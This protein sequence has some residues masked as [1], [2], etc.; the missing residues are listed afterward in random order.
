VPVGASSFTLSV[1][2][3]NSSGAPATLV[4]W[5]DFDRDNVF[6][7]DEA[8]TIAIPDGTTSATPVS[9]AWPAIPAGTTVGQSYLRLRLSSDAGLDASAIQGNLIDGE[10]E[11]HPITIDVG[12]VDLTIV[13]SV[14]TPEAEVGSTVTFTL[15]VNN[16]GPADATN[17]VVTDIVPAGFT[18]VSNSMTG[19]N[20]RNQ[21]SP[22]G[23]GLVWTINSLVDGGTE[24]V[25]TFQAVV[26]SP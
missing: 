24:V 9:L 21:S 11:D 2:V 20:S 14:D 15:R 25:L 26:N 13:K 7:A 16:L 19:G 18:F 17:I 1:P 5:I 6:Q 10:V 12:Q 3:T 4:G 23:T 8:A 22:A